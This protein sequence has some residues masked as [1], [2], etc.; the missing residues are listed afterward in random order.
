MPPIQLELKPSVTLCILLVLMSVVACGIVILQSWPWQIKLALIALI[1]PAAS[2]ALLLHGLRRLPWSFVAV[3]I[4]S[5]QQLQFKCRDGNLVDVVVQGNSVVLPYL[6]II[7]MQSQAAT[8]RQWLAQPSV[9]ILADAVE[10]NAFRRLR[11][12]LRWS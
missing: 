5:M 4:N 10:A 12:C 11:V 9:I 6:T 2:Y 1:M 3:T 8:W 7:N